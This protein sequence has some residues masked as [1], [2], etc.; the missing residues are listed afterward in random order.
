MA[1]A[2]PEPQLTVAIPT[3]NGAAHLA[4]ALHSV[5]SQDGVAFDLIVSDDHSD[6]DTV[7]VVR[8]TVGEGA[9]IDDT[10]RAPG[11]RRQLEPLRG[12]LPHAVSGDLPSRRRHDARASESARRRAGGDDRLGLVA[13]AS[14]VIDERGESVAPSVVD[15][16]GLGPLDRTFE[17]G[18][19]AA[20]MTLGNPLRCSAMTMRLAAFAEAVVSTGPTAMCSTGISG[21]GFRGSGGSHGS[22]RRR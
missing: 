3:Y 20:E 9:Q 10:P 15:P 4:D 1:S 6:D 7:E 12:T 18:T 11:P 5:L 14:E 21:C 19:L 13:G 16:G 8:A 22:R 2:M 17:P